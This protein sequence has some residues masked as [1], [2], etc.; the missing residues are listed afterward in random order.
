MFS[1]H[2]CCLKFEFAIVCVGRN[3]N[4]CYF[5]YVPLSWVSDDGI[6]ELHGLL[7]FVLINFVRGNHLYEGEV[8]S[9]SRACLGGALQNSEAKSYSANAAWKTGNF[10]DAIC[11][12]TTLVDCKPAHGLSVGK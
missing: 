12:G 8:E 6:F 1:P 5:L 3:Y 7:Q 4:C 10:V 11:V 2:Q 9:E